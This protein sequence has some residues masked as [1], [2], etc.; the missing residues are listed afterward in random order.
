[1]LEP[2]ES[3]AWERTVEFLCE[4]LELPIVLPKEA[5]EMGKAE[6]ARVFGVDQGMVVPRGAEPFSGSLIE[7]N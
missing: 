3:A 1:M 6:K 4:I 7:M 2:R 5:K